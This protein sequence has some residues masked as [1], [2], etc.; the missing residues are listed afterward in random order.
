MV[1]ISETVC[2]SRNHACSRIIVANVPC[3]YTRGAF[4]TRQ[5]L[6]RAR[7][8][9]AAL[10]QRWLA[11]TSRAS[12]KPH[13]RDN[14]SRDDTRDKECNFHKIIQVLQHTFIIGWSLTPNLSFGEGMLLCASPRNTT[15]TYTQ[16]K[17]RRWGST[18][19]RNGNAKVPSTRCLHRFWR[20]S[21]LSEIKLL[22][23]IKP[24]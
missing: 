2:D 9:L 1:A 19:V 8:Q 5:L 22:C 6:A 13:F 14:L 7:Y 16:D 20:T 23:L 18:I 15:R 4:T 24:I 17:P 3:N 10:E 11:T 21:L 12:Q